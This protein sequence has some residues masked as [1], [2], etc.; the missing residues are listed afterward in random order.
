M[1]QSVYHTSFAL[2]HM[3]TPPPTSAQWDQSA[4]IAA[5]NNM[6]PPSQAGWIIDSGSTSHMSSENGTIPPLLPL[7][8]PVY[9]T[10]GNGARV[11]VYFYSSMH[12]YL[13]SSNF[14]LKSVLRVPSLIQNLIS[15]RQFTRDNAVS[16]EFDSFGFSVKDLK[17]RRVIIRY[18]SSGDLYT[19]PPALVAPSHQ[20]F[21]SSAAPAPIWHARLGH[22]GPTVL[23]KL[24]S[25]SSIVCNKSTHSM[26]HT[27]QLGKHVWLPFSPLVSSSQ[28]PFELLHCDVWT[29]PITSIYGFKYYL[30]VLDDFTHFC[31][32]FP[33][34][35]KSDVFTTFINF[36]SYART[37]FDLP[38]KIIQA[39]NRTEFINSHFSTLH[40][41][42][43]I[44]TR[45]SCSFTSSQNGKAERMLCT[46]N[47]TVRTLLIHTFM[48]P[49]YCVKAL[50]TA[51][52]LINRLPS[53]ET[54]TSTPFQ[55]L[56]NKELT[57]DNLR[58][59]DCLYYPNTS[60]IT[61]HKLPP[62]SVPYVF[63]C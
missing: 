1:Y 18:N 19:I 31:W 35:Y 60:A 13:A 8:Y 30:V 48:P 7:P 5:L 41:H 51:T 3:P 22:P 32:T 45:F 36:H 33:L 54:P 37:Q 29:L 2:L 59:L 44:I 61:A 63:L 14:V 34:K 53:T 12:L 23:N 55:L 17:T 62:R 4:L 47:N 46:I 15:V 24:Q 57:Y 6:A 52:F 42:H 20:A 56:H 49:T 21:I 10:I 26:C 39:D 25:S 11:S 58:V 38:I 50:S 28:C 40:A 27:C 43:G 16:I 9:V